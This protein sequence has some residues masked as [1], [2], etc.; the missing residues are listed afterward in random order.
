MAAR[1]AATKSKIA[2]FRTQE[3][4]KPHDDKLPIFELLYESIRESLPD[5]EALRYCFKLLQNFKSF[6]EAKL[7]SKLVAYDV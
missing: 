2:S 5:S 3:T 1:Y 6:Y 7:T 4:V